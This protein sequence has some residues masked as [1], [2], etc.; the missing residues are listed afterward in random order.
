MM[1]VLE[2]AQ[3]H[4]AELVHEL[5]T[6]IVIGTLLRCGASQ[7][8]VFALGGRVA[9]VLGPGEHQLSPERVPFVQS[10]VHPG[11]YGPAIGGSVFLARTGG[12]AVLDVAGSLSA[13]IDRESGE[14]RVPKLTA[15]VQVWIADA[16]RLFTEMPKP[17]DGAAERW[18]KEQVVVAVGRAV[19]DK[20]PTS[21][22]DAAEYP[23]WAEA[24]RQVLA[25][26]LA[27]RGI[28]LGQL[29]LLSIGLPEQARSLPS[30]EMPGGEAAMAM[31]VGARVRTSASSK[32]YSGSIL[33]LGSEGARVAWDSDGGETWV[34]TA[35]LEPEPKYP[36][37]YEPGTRVLATWSDGAFY[38]ATVRLFNGT[39]YQVAWEN[40][41]SAWL[42][43]G[44]IKL[45]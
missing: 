45:S 37:S 26:T 11:P 2:V 13:S 15:K 19:G 5:P 8:A 38:P 3:M 29:E 42:E 24:T 17:G 20:D 1:P 14:R 27:Q 32:W 23:R 34:P 10:L 25:P 44:R 31:A 16:W 39:H 33:E 6:P 22:G 4:H 12:G 21:L 18:V 36:G 28:G 40:G 35:S 30:K 43:P 41:E 7:S 9:G